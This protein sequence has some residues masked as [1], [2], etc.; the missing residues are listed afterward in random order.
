M[1]N[2]RSPRPPDPWRALT[3]QMVAGWAAGVGVAHQEH[4]GRPQRVEHCRHVHRRRASSWQ[5]RSGAWR[6]SLRVSRVRSARLR[7]GGQRGMSSELHCCLLSHTP[8]GHVE[9]ESCGPKQALDE[10]VHEG[11]R[12]QRL[13]KLQVPEDEDCEEAGGDLEP[14]GDVALVVACADGQGCTWAVRDIASN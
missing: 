12:P 13:T 9:C 4:E 6:R 1:H 14:D 7:R 11:R 10:M 2:T 3:I 8:A 5:G